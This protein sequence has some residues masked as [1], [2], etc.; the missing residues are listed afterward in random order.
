MTKPNIQTGIAFF[1]S[2]NKAQA[3]K[4][5]LT[6]TE[7]EPQN[8]IAWLWLAACE[9]KVEKKQTYLHKALSINPDNRNAQKALAELELDSLPST[10]PSGIVLK[11]PSCGSPMGEPDDTGLVQCRYCGTSVTYSPPAR[12][13]AQKNIERYLELCRLA[14]KGRNFQEALQYSNKI[15]EIDPENASGW[16]IK[17]IAT[18][19]LT[20]IANNRFEEAEGYLA[21]AKQ[22]N[23]NDLELNKILGAMRNNQAL[24][25]V[26]LASKEIKQGWEIYGIYD[27][28]YSLSDAIADTILGSQSSKQHS[29]QHFVNGMNYLLLANKYLPDN[30]AILDLIRNLAKRTNW[31]K[32]SPDTKENMV[33][34]INMEQK[35]NAVRELPELLKKRKELQEELKGLGEEDGLFTSIIAD[36]IEKQIGNL[37]VQISSFEKIAN[38]K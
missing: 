2:G 25:H 37:E 38:L 30:Y 9:E 28:H 33:R 13:V 22:I 11:C 8:E 26:E 32:W 19:W 20:T 17:A 14:L 21:K 10:K 31:I 24:W 15:L 36:G 23:K 27:T 5:F 29:Y 34:V 6:I 12:K 18:C 4:I 1:K 16:K 3:S 7:L 35:Q